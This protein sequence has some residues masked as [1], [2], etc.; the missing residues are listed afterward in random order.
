[1]SLD[2]SYVDVKDYK[3][4]CLTPEGEIRK[5]T[6]AI[7]W[8]TMMTGLYEVKESNLDEWLIRI[9][10]LNTVRPGTIDVNLGDLRRHVGLRTNARRC[11]LAQF[12][13][14]VAETLYDEAKQEYKR[15]RTSLDRFKEEG[16]E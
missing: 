10:M 14:M 9:F 13:K 4:V 11:T 3:T 12:R 5:K 2:F 16:G 15:Q 8:G 7:I 6:E 1:M